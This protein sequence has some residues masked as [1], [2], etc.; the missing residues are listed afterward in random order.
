ML[1]VRKRDGSIEDFNQEKIVESIFRSAQAVGGRDREMAKR[2]ANEVVAIIQTQCKGD[3]VS[4][5]EIG[6]IVEKVLIERGHART[7]KAYILYRKHQEELRKLRSTSLEVERIV[8]SYIGHMDWR[9]REN[10]N[11]DFSLSGLEQHISTTVIAN[12]T[13]SKLYPME[14]ADA[15]SNGD[16][17]IHD[18]GRG[19][20]GYCAGWSLQQLLVEGFNGVPNR[21]GSNP[22]KHLTTALLQMVNF[23]GTLSNEWAGAMAFNSID[24]LLAPFV[25]ADKMDYGEVKQAIQEFVFNLNVTSRFG[26]QCPFTNVT[27]DLNVPPDLVNKPA[28]VGGKPLDRTYGEFTEE[29]EMINRAFIEVLSEGDMSGR[30]FT[31]PIPT[32]SITK[33]FEWD[34]PLSDILFEATAKYGQPYFQNFVNSDLRPSDVRSMCCRLRLDLRELRNKMSGGLFGAGDSTGSMGVVTINMPRLGYLS[35]NEDE[36]FERLDQIMELAKRSLEIKREIVEKNMNNGLLPFTKRYLGNLN[37][38]FSTI[39]LVGMNEALLNLFDQDITTDQGKEFAIRVLKHMRQRLV[40][41]QEETGHLYNLEAT[42]A[43]GTSYR[44]ALID[45]RK[46]PDIITAGERVPYYTNSSQLPVN[47][48]L[49][50]VEALEHQEDLQTLYTGGTVFHTWLGERIQGSAAK[51]LLQRMTNNSRLP[52]FTL[53]PTFSIC[54]DHSYFPGEHKVCPQCGKQTE[55]YSRVVGY[56]RPVANWSD[57]KREE[58]RQRKYFG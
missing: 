28:I 35:K 4:T 47:S 41:F 38:H 19:I 8:D 10:A 2:L 3:I 39:G 12:Y 11:I 9:V 29:M 26:G 49:D 50:L 13:L 34:S 53:T 20:C 57:G 24:T 22:P 46:Y 1:K 54:P 16:F 27:L 21:I 25:W 33:D 32:Y 56:L 30:P 52:Y 45:K 23:M 6:N 40:E 14:V 37:Q 17:H 58:F 31:F 51:L 18:L 7:A 36:F 48:G 5:E 55:V 43:E 44:L 15:H 42:P